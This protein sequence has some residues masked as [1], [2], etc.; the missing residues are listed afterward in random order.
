MLEMYYDSV[1]YIKDG[2]WIGKKGFFYDFGYEENVILN[3]CLNYSYVA[4]KILAF[5]RDS[6]IHVYSTKMLN[7]Q[8]I[9]YP[10]KLLEFTAHS[11]IAY[12][13]IICES[14]SCLIDGNCQI[15]FS[16]KAHIT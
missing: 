3:G 5:K 10:E 13:K 16:E 1:I 9:K 6:K 14:Y 11:H 15:K 7:K 2:M 12:G 4:N 8:E